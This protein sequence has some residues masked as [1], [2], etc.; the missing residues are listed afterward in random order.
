[1]VANSN[2]AR[3][4]GQVTH[5]PSEP[6]TCLSTEDHD[7]NIRD[8]V[9]HYFG[10]IQICERSNFFDGKNHFWK[11]LEQHPDFAGKGEAK[12]RVNELRMKSEKTVKDHS[13]RTRLLVQEIAS[14]PAAKG[15]KEGKGGNLVAFVAESREAWRKSPMYLEGISQVEAWSN[16]PKVVET[17]PKEMRQPPYSLEEDVNAYI[18]QYGPGVPKTT[19]DDDSSAE[20]A[21]DHDPSQ[22]NTGSRNIQSDDL[23]P[24]VG[25][26]DERLKGMFPD[27]RLPI[28]CLLKKDTTDLPFLSR[29]GNGNLIRYFHFPSNNMRASLNPRSVCIVNSSMKA[30]YRRWKT[31]G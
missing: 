3:L 20:N 28:A 14:K 21:V 8:W 7:H 5:E 2:S 23:L 17:L 31:V 10:C 16:R 4:D 12:S 11:S 1:M 18:I 22:T 6:A 29:R 26:P 15:G 19:K 30:D 9:S 27:Q 24:L 13:N 25:K